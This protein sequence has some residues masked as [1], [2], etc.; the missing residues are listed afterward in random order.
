MAAPPRLH[1]PL[2]LHE[3]LETGL[4][5]GAARHV[6]VLRLQPGAALTLF[7][8]RGGEW[9]AR[10]LQIGRREVRVRIGAF[11][12]VSR[13]LPAAVTLAVGMPANE[14]MDALV[15]K[16]C[17]LGVAALQP[18]V[19]ERSVLRLAGERAERKVQHWQAVA[20]AASEQCGRTRVPVV[21]PVRSLPDWLA[22]LA[23]ATAQPRLV[24]SLRDAGA[25]PAAGSFG[26]LTALSGPEGGLSEA[27][28]E[29]AR[30]RGFLPVSLGARTLRADTAPLALLAHLAISLEGLA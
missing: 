4:P 11:D 19:C 12:E 10:V 14:R 3:G 20:V 5:E 25:L 13:E 24:L 6:Q 22:G 7:D 27:E 8:G 15:E 21:A 1:V 28:E 30:R 17:E 18:L 23:A 26:E 9:A 29:A 16:A 2:P